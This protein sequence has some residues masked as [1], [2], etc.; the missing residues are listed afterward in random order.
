MQG[1]RGERIG[2][3]A[4][5]AKLRSVGTP[6]HLVWRACAVKETLELWPENATIV[7]VFHMLA[8]SQ[9]NVASHSV[10]VTWLGLRYEAIPVVA[11]ALAV[12]AD[13]RADLLWGIHVME[14]EARRILNGDRG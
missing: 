2:D 10:G 8:G 9:W 11:D 7:R 4:R 6:E 5:A 13:Q 12:P 1:G 3:E 14:A